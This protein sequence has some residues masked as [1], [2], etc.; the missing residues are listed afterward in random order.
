MDLKNQMEQD[1][2]T[3]KR[4]LLLRRLAKAVTHA[5]ELVQ[6]T[7]ARCDARTNL[8]AEAYCAWLAGTL[9][10]EKESDWHSALTAFHRARQLLEGLFQVGDFDQRA[11]CRHFLDQ[12]EPAVRYCEYQI[13]RQG[14]SAQDAGALLAASP[15]AAPPGDILSSKLAS[16]AAEAQAARA[17]VVSEI[18]WNGESLPVREE[19]CRIA[20]HTVSELEKELHNNEAGGDRMEGVEAAVDPRIALYDRIINAYG[21]ARAAARAAE[22]L[23]QHGDGAEA[24][25][26]ELHSLGRA[27]HGLQLQRTISRNL[28]LAEVAA[29]RLANALRRRV[30]AEKERSSERPVRP[31]DVARLYDTLVTNATELNDL[32]AEVGGTQGEAL[33]EECAAKLA[34]F[35]AARCLYSAHA[36]LAGGHWN[37]AA[38]LFKRAEERCLQATSKCDECQ[39][40]DTGA[41]AHLQRLRNEAIAYGVVAAAESRAAELEAATATAD[42]VVAMDLESSKSGVKRQ[43]EGTTYMA[44][45]LDVWEAFAGVGVSVPRIAR[46]PPPPALVPIRPIVLDAALM[47]IEPPSVE[48]R[49]PKKGAAEAA[50]G[51]VSRL[52]GWGR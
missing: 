50:S 42:G 48:H 30:T 47:S 8:E 33:M 22:Q 4:H 3:G 26:E 52:F 15:A 41:K 19:R 51:M 25:R 39:A 29:G 6:L 13:G 32:A 17:V 49:A 7:A 31:D 40:P 38:A 28:F 9:L 34:Y 24:A 23:G 1:M 36:Q 21:D 45:D 44:D 16:L 46:I 2:E 18:I 43:R 10:L 27:L 11:T 37:E 20:V 12:V 14:G 35:Q 5:T